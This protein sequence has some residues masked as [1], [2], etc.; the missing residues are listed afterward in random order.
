MSGFVHLHVHSDYSALDG[1]CKV[2]D[3]VEKAAA[4]GMPA[5]ALT[6]HGVLSGAV[7]FYQKAVKAGVKP[8]LGL[9]AYVVEDR[10]HKDRQSE[11]RWHL[12]LLA[13]TNEGYQNLLRLG[14]R[15][16]L[17][18]YYIKPRVDYELLQQY[19]DGLICLSGCPTGRLSKSLERGQKEDARR[20]VE[21]LCG[22]FGRENV[23]IEIQ[24]TGVPDLEG[25]PEAVAELAREVGLPL[26]AT[27]DIHYLEH[28]DAPA[29]DVLL[30]IQTG[31][32]LSEEKRL[33]FSSEEFY[34]KS[35]EEMRQAFA[36]Y[37]EAVDN[38]L[39]VAE[40][41]NVNLEFDRILLPSYEVPG[42]FADEAAYLRHLCEEGISRR[43]GAD[44]GPE[45]RERLEME[46]ATIGQMGF[47]AY[48]LIVWDFVSFSKRA[49]IP[50]GPGR[51]S[52]AGSLVA[53]LLGITELDPLKH[54]LLFERFLNP[55]RVSM[56][57]IDI[58]FSVE[59]R[60]RVIEYVA[61]KY[62]RDRVAQIGTF[63][64]IKA[65]Q[66]I[67][68]A[69]RV[70]DVPY[71]VADRIA[72]LVPEGPKVTLADALADKQDLRAEYDKDEEVRRVV[73]VA[74]P[75]EGLIRQE[76]IHAAGVVI[77]DRP[78]T[79]YLPLQQ[80]G[81]AEVVTQFAMGDVEKLGLLKMDFLGLRNLDVL[82]EAVRIIRE[83]DPAFDL[84]AIPFDDG[85]TYRML[86][87]G[88]SEGV[89]QFESTGMQAALREVGP[90]TFDDL[91]ALVALYR[92]GPMEFIPTFARNKRDPALV[93][94]VDP[95]LEPVLKP[96][97]GVAIYQEQL[98]DISKRIGGFTPSEADDLRKAIG[99]KNRAILD[100]L[101]PKFREG[102][103]AGGAAPGVV[104]HLWSL[105]EKAGDY[106]FNKSHAACYALIAYQTAYL[107]AN[108]PVE[109]MAA[110]ISSVMNTKDKVPFYVTVANEMGIEVLP[111]DINESAI[112]FRVVE[113]RIRFGLNAVK[114]VGET[115]IKCILA[116]REEAGGFS[117]IFDFCARVDLTTV[118]QRA[119]ESLIKAGGLD[120]TGYSRLGMLQVLPQAMSF[121]KK[122]Q[123]DAT[124]GQGSIFDLL[125]V[126]PE[127]KKAPAGAAAAGTGRGPQSLPVPIPEDDFSKE[128]RLAQEKET[129]GLF[130]S[131]H[132]LRGLRHQIQAETTH[133]I[134]HLSEVADGQEV[135]IVGM[136]SSV[137][138]ITTKKNHETM[139]FV[140]L[141]GV[142]GSVEMLCFPRMYSDNREILQEDRVVK[143]RGKVDHKDEVE[144][145]LI[146]FAVEPFVARTGDEPVL[147]TLDGE[148]VPATVIDDL[149]LVLH[150]FPGPCPVQV[151]V[152]TSADRFLL[153]FGEGYRVDPQ[154]SLFAELKVLLGEAAVS[155]QGAPLVGAVSGL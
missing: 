43:F 52:A 130:L 23:Y 89:F 134:S 36:K 96:T 16:F 41:C 63:G 46:L 119:I 124:L 83:Q 42:G 121:A 15:A 33:R 35:E 118:N 40:R 133:L 79:D 24:E 44:P 55:G 138:R 77:S 30:C 155:W 142:E 97:Y 153:R 72:K 104:D 145:K 136:V 2:G 144:T 125:S 103:L 21:R 140:T 90:T 115:A 7:Q 9:E 25:V 122:T 143:V 4:Y 10:L 105:M 94:Y 127:G 135:T 126:A 57:D 110:L 129:L 112:N 100:R 109:Y 28:K 139:A 39:L 85:K 87:R 49:G 26:V 54:D 18:G 68:D 71:G 80:K 13:S 29:H 67:R 70:M 58:D 84:A 86:T 56:P 65:R 147:L 78:L 150:H 59:G 123:A 128:E 154:T 3:L 106:S 12:T 102:A 50:V 53:Y 91:I 151:E 51:G 101:Q 108:Y 20:E 82:A 114:N 113:G 37:P 6:D 141:D 73:D 69:A 88:D 107:K 92:P 1:A 75:I 111:P 31:S 98:M 22:L 76:S 74:R 45:V 66:A 5:L 34:F 19:A 61:E 64:T 38:T 137:K 146:P 47:P 27:N 152:V 132:P 95:R 14:S 120:S 8:I 117:D 11:E 17:E 131:S 32:R 99:K 116:A 60:D 48:F 62:G 93:T 81:D 149:K 148:G